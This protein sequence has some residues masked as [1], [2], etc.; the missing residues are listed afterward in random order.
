MMNDIQKKAA[1]RQFLAQVK[2]RQHQLNVASPQ[3]FQ[4]ELVFLQEEVATKEEAIAFLCQKLQASGAVEGHFLQTVM[5]REAMVPTVLET[6]VAIPH[7]YFSEVKYAKIAV[8]IPKQPIPWS[9]GRE[10]KVV[11]MLAFTEATSHLF[12]NIYNVIANHQLVDQIA[13]SNER[14]QVIEYL[15]S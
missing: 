6:G 3:L 4:P 2:E 1:V 14:D 10:A 12:G 9:N 7:G 5:D 11:L 15:N 8:L 13:A